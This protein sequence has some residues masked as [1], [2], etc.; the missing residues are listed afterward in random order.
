MALGQIARLA[1]FPC[2]IAILKF[3]DS[4]EIVYELVLLKRVDKKSQFLP[5]KL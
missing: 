3:Y 4:Y 2:R 1:G 5:L